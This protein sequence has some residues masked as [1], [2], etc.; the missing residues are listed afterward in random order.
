MERAVTPSFASAD[1]L[2]PPVLDIWINP[3]TYTGLPPVYLTQENTLANPQ[4]DDDDK[5]EAGTAQ[6][7]AA[8]EPT[9]L[10]AGSQLRAQL[11]GS[12]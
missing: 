10:I 1:N 4:G 11:Q 5:T 8:P 6:S 2:P 9:D 3:P 12:Q 7:G